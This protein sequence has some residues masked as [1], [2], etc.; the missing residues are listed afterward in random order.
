[1]LRRYGLSAKA[2]FLIFALIL[3]ALFCRIAVLNFN[4]GLF[5]DKLLNT[6]RVFIYLGLFAFWGVSIRRRVMQRE[7][8]NFLTATALLLFSWLLIRELK[9]HYIA[10][11]DVQRYLWYL[12][13]I[14]ILALPSLALF[15]SLLAGKSENERLRKPLLFLAAPSMLLSLLVLTNDLHQLVFV[16]PEDAISWNENDFEYGALF[17]FIYAWAVL[18][19][20]ASFMVMM[21]KS[22]TKGKR[23]L[24]L[25]PLIPIGVAA[26]YAALYY[27]LPSELGDLAAVY[28]LSLAA[29]YE[30]C[31]ITG[32]IPSNRRYSDL[33]SASAGISAQIS[34]KDYNVVYAARS[35]EPL[36]KGYMMQAEEKPLILKEGRRLRSMAVP[37][38]HAFWIEDI[39]ELLRLRETLEERKEELEDR[40]ALLKYEYEREKEQKKVEEQNRLYDLLQSKTQKQLNRIEKLVNEYRKEEGE[41]NRRKILSEIVF[42]GSYIKRRKDF[43]LSME[44]EELIEAA[45]LESALNESFRALK[46]TGVSCAFSVNSGI[47]EL[48]AEL[49]TEAYDFFECSAELF[50]FRMKYFNLIVSAP[51]NKARVM[52]ETDAFFDIEGEGEAELMREYPSLIRELDEDGTALILI[53]EGGAEA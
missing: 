16:F 51:G 33:F 1:M 18:T 39:Y 42:L 37:G 14:P 43:I 9:W 41:E 52:I 8:S 53:L 24:V 32:L 13:Y 11:E 40:N 47:D 21:L 22:F 20:L 6:L 25:L 34:D 45:R 12:Y 44:A 7:M 3:T 30:S 23:D 36:P 46:N 49:I 35:A 31:I 50:L 17:Y 29:F 27:F 15:V 10:G 28:C 2:V 5:S 26:L 48:P 19:A 4:P 38:G